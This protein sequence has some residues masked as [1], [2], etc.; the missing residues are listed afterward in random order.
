[1][2]FGGESGMRRRPRLPVQRRWWADGAVDAAHEYAG[3]G[4]DAADGS[5]L[6]LIHRVSHT[7]FWWKPKIGNLSGRRLKSAITAL[8]FSNAVI[9]N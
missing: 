3:R 7:S 1:M 8:W 4:G 6:I 2:F 5:G 9:S